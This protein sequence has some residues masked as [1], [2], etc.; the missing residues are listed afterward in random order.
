MTESAPPNNTTATPPEPVPSP[1]EVTQQ[2]K[3]PTGAIVG[4]VV[5]GVGGLL[6]L[7]LG[8][9]WLWQRRANRERHAEAES[10]ETQSIR[11]APVTAGVVDLDSKNGPSNV[12]PFLPEITSISNASLSDQATSVMPATGSEIGT[13]LP[14]D[15]AAAPPASH[16]SKMLSAGSRKQQIS[17]PS[18]AITPEISQTPRAEAI[19]Q[20]RALPSVPRVQYA[21][22]A[23]DAL[24]QD[25]DEPLI[26]PPRYKEAWGRR[27]L[28][29]S[30]GP[31]VFRADDRDGAKPTRPYQ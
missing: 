11:G 20:A 24:P 12:S 30:H 9:W 17:S 10:S 3:S 15:P 22:D 4:G 31:A 26:L 8:A 19:T 1:A 25:P 18:I 14:S 27:E 16:D 5:G 2:K 13:A 28:P 29:G 7:L 23:E 21:E 6:L